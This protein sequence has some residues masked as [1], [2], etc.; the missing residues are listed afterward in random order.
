MWTLLFQFLYLQMSVGLSKGL[1]VGNRTVINIAVQ[2]LFFTYLA[3]S[4]QN[5]LAVSKEKWGIHK[6]HEIT[7]IPLPIQGQG[8]NR[9]Q[10]GRVIMSSPFLA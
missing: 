3:I 8:Y 2:Y 5:K 6:T 7:T 4:C 9:L 1:V 10:P